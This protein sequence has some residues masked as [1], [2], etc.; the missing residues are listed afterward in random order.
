MNDSVVS[1]P[2]VAAMLAFGR[3]DI[4]LRPPSS[5]AICLPTN[6][7][8]LL[9]SRVEQQRVSGTLWAAIENGFPVTPLQRVEAAQLH[10][11]SMTML[12]KLEATALWLVGLLRDADVDA[13]IIKGLATAHIVHPTPEHRASGDVDLLVSPDQF[14]TALAALT[15]AG[16]RRQGSWGEGADS[17]A[18]EVVFISDDIEIDLHQS[19]AFGARWRRATA[20]LM[21][22]GLDLPFIIKGQPVKTLSIEGLFISACVSAARGD[23]R[24]SGLVDIAT[25]SHRPDLDL[26]R[27]RQLL[28]REGL[29]PMIEP[30]L[31]LT[32]RHLKI[33]PQVL[34]IVQTSLAG[35][36]HRLF[37]RLERS[38]G[39]AR[40]LYSCLS[41]TPRSWPEGLRTLL[42]PDDAYF[43][44]EGRS[45]SSNW[46][47]VA[48]RTSE[49]FLRPSIYR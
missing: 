14:R 35:R 32:S 28:E 24:L 1:E 46:R 2:V 6:D 13:R 10:H 5:D 40:Y 42:V 29:A 48:D 37:S 47:R 31:Q 43:E 49:M 39:G 20:S 19:L 38:D 21:A 4:A 18:K 36:H 26:I 33:N 45:K 30:V 44:S 9:L 15:R 12:V 25:L 23:G 17:F 7:W 8:Q 11:E 41:G 34:H 3:P 16:V 22:N 27:V